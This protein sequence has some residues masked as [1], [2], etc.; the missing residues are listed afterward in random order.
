MGMNNKRVGLENIKQLSRELSI[1]I[2]QW[3]FLCSVS[4]GSHK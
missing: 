2:S 3:R 4:H 1:K